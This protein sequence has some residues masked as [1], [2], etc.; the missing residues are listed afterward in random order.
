MNIQWYS[1]CNY[2]TEQGFWD[3]FTRNVISLISSLF[4]VV[5]DRGAF[6]S[7]Y[8]VSIKYTVIN[9]FKANILF[10]YPVK[11]SKRFSDVFRG[12]R[13]ETLTWKG[14]SYFIQ[15]FSL[16]TQSNGLTKKAVSFLSVL[17][18]FWSMLPLGFVLAEF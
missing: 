17:I 13:N 2:Q 15:L 1:Y 7:C 9:L 4:M 6:V 14:S 5:F 10:A 3:R 11:T 18:I 12:Y 8:Q 16:F